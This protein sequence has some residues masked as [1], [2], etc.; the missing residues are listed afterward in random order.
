LLQELHLK[1]L[2][3]QVLVPAKRQYLLF[4]IYEINL[5]CQDITKPRPFNP[6]MD[7]WRRGPSSELGELIFCIMAWLELMGK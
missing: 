7:N 5:T 3:A 4:T 6:G 1:L 2:I